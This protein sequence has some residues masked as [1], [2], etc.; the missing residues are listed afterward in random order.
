M[1]YDNE[2]KD[3]ILALM[4]DRMLQLGFTKVTL[5]EIASELGIS[6]KTLY[7]YFAGKDELAIE[8]IRSHFSGI[9]DDINVIV[10]SPAPFTEKLQNLMMLQRKQLGRFNKIAMDDIRKH[11]PQL[12]KEIETI[13]RE[14]LLV[15][16]ETMFESA[17]AERVFRPGVDER[18]VLR[19]MLA[20][21]EAVANPDTA[22]A[23]SLSIREVIHS[24]FQVL[25][26]GALTDEAKAKIPVFEHTAG[27]GH[28]RRSSF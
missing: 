26:G 12:W 22:A 2:L 15:K 23:M 18:I 1:V 6:K 25:F 27:A 28:S 20:S 8:A 14:N 19:M 4:R 5:D 17:R 11:A 7:K 16:I 3:R 10:S 9:G 13:R 21:V 24:I